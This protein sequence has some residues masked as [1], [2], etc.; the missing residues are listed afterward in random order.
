[1]DKQI[2]T[3]FYLIGSEKSDLTSTRVFSCCQLAK[4]LRPLINEL[5]LTAQFPFNQFHKHNIT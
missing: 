1:M 5:C 3:I 4:H 2:M